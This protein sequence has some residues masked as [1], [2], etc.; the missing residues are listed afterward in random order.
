MF[1]GFPRTIAVLPHLLRK[2]RRTRKRIAALRPVTEGLED[3]TLLSTIMWNTAVAPSGGD[4]DTASDWVGGVIPGAADNAVIDLTSSGTVTHATSA[5][6]A[7][8]NLT[9]NASTTVSLTN[10]SIAIVQRAILRRAPI[11]PSLTHGSSSARPRKH[12]PR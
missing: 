3:R 12:A 11:C 4:W 10:G 7:A 6:D 8:L 5:N 9:T 1:Q 2:R